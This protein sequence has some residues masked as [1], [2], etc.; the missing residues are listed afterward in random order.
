[1]IVFGIKVNHHGQVL[2][3]EA[4]IQMKDHRTGF[5]EGNS[6]VLEIYRFIK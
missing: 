4:R 3:K 5:V 1:M 6:L 2:M